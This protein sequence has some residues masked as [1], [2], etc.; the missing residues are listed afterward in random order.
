MLAELKYA[1]KRQ[2]WA[3]FCFIAEDLGFNRRSWRKELPE[4]KKKRPR[5]NYLNGWWFGPYD[6]KSRIPILNQCI[7]ETA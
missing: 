6:H 1:Q 3:S 5:V 2:T 7:K 4:L